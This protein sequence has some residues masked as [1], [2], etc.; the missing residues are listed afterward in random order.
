MDHVKTNMPQ[1]SD[2]AFPKIHAISHYSSDIK[3]G[4]ETSEYSA[5]MWENL[6][7]TLMKNPAKGS[8]FKNVEN[9]LMNHH[10]ESWSLSALI[11]TIEDDDDDE[12][13]MQTVTTEVNWL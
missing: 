8:N 9:Q 1:T 3:R 4:G 11:E 2:W 6:H 5:D 12:D 13:D 10:S 7:K